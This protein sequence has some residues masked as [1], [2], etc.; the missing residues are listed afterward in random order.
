MKHISALLTAL[1]LCTLPALT[2]AAPG[3]IKGKT[4]KGVS[5][6]SLD[7]AAKPIKI[8]S[9]V[10]GGKA[11]DILCDKSLKCSYTGADGKSHESQAK[12]GNGAGGKV[13]V[14]I[15]TP[16]GPIVII[17][18]KNPKPDDG[19]GDDGDDK[20]GEGSGGSSGDPKTDAPAEPAPK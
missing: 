2:S 19:G 12:R 15:P 20:G 3:P 13:E 17:V 7:A 9:A 6:A 1:A 11:T 5:V 14:H 8:G 18:T 16:F 4:A 10:L